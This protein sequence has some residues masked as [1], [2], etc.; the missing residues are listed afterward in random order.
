M[1]GGRTRHAA[2]LVWTALAGVTICL[3][4]LGRGALGP[5]PWLHPQAALSWWQERGSLL[6]TFAVARDILWWA[7]CY[8][9]ALWTIAEIASWRHSFAVIRLLSRCRLPGAGAV[10]RTTVGASALGA[11][12][13]S[14]AVPGFAEGGSAG[15]SVSG[16]APAASAPPVLRY[17]GA[18]GDPTRATPNAPPPVLRDTG[19]SGQ[20]NRTTPTA[21]PPIPPH[22]GSSAQPD[23][24]TPTAP[25]PVLP[26][27]RSSGQPNRTTP[28]TPSPAAGPP[29]PTTPPERQHD[30][31]AG[32]P[33]P[34]AEGPRIKPAPHGSAARAQQPA[35]PVPPV[36][37]GL[38]SPSPS[39]A[40][41]PAGER[42]PQ[43]PTLPQSRSRPVRWWTVR[44]G[45]NLWSIAEATLAEAWG[46]IPPE[47]VLARYWWQ[48]V[49]ANR[50]FLPNPADPNLLFP[51][52]RVA[53][54]ALPSRTD[55][56]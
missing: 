2:A 50:P 33:A 26:D 42:R 55:P 44:P 49:Q 32:R 29:A 37:E 18:A 35:R 27:T 48:V 30:I 10:V 9:L 53:I 46:R 24:T 39:S 45:D 1:S 36:R 8:L 21:P 41:R 38:A 47:R 56:T 5:P 14:T 52:D 19:G 34:R 25:P 28:T 15:T 22:T 7:G 51:G 23:G 40:A 20:P 43:R 31:G 12:L 54:P 3:H 16:G 11:V 17:A 4:A 13:L 6:A